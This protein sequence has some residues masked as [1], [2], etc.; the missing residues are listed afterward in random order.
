MPTWTELEDRFLTLEP[1]LGFARLDRQ[2][3][4]DGEHWRLAA[5]FD[6][7]SSSR[8][9]SLATIAGKKLLEFLGLE[10]LPEEVRDA[11]SDKIRWYRALAQNPRFYNV[12]H[13]GHT[14]DDAGNKIGWIASGSINKPAAVAASYCLELSSMKPEDSPQIS[15]LTI[16]VSGQNARLNVASFDNSSNTATSVD[17][18]IFQNIQNAIKTSITNESQE[19]LLQKLDELQAAV[20]SP[21]YSTKYKEFIQLAA[22][23]MSI[24]APFLPILS[25][26]L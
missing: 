18:A 7:I 23:H 16:N 10:S 15:P 11:T 21:T 8:F 2:T 14:L 4:T 17:T 9:E 20:S 22:N 25:S 12:E 6:S 3:G 1:K 24:L 5:S 13:F 19:L 26:F